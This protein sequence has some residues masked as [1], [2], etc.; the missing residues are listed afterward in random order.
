MP[1]YNVTLSA[2]NGEAPTVTG[3]VWADNDEA[4][5]AM[6][7]SKL[8]LLR[9][10]RRAMRPLDEWEVW[11]GVPPY[12]PHKTVAAGRMVARS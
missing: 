3:R 7:I 8:A 6:A 9:A 10:T 1:R 2:S 4:A 5:K 11:Q 12:T